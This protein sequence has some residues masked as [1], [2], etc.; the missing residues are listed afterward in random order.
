M[1]SGAYSLLLITYYLAPCTHY[2]LLGALRLAPCAL[3]FEL[4]SPEDSSAG[5]GATINNLIMLI[6]DIIEFY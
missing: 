1:A 4:H 6:G 5:H 3:E 2:L